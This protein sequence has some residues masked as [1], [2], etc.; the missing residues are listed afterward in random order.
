MSQGQGIQ[1]LNKVLVV[2]SVPFG[3]FV[4]GASEAPSH[5]FFPCL[6]IPPVYKLILWVV[7]WFGE[8]D[9]E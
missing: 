8:T 1:K 7:R 6:S 4:H 5:T 9:L 2:T 3:A